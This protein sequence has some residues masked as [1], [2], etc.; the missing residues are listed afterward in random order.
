MVSMLTHYPA[1][2]RRGGPIEEWGHAVDAELFETFTFPLSRG[3]PASALSDPRSL[4]LAPGT[5]AKYFGDADPMGQTLTLKF[6][7]FSRD[8]GDTPSPEVR[9]F[10]VT[11]ILA[12]IPDKSSIR[13]NMVIPK[14]G[15]EDLTPRGTR[16]LWVE[17][18]EGVSPRVVEEQLAK[19]PQALLPPR[20][21][22]GTP[23]SQPIPARH[24]ARLPTHS[25]VH[26]MPLRDVH[27]Q[28]G[29][30][31][32]PSGGDRKRG[33][34]LAGAGL[35]ILLIACINYVNLAVARATTRATEIGIRKAVGADRAQVRRQ[36]M[37]EAI[38]VSFLAVALG[39]G[40]AELLL[41]EFR[42]LVGEDLALDSLAWRTLTA[43][44]VLSLV[45]GGAAGLYPSVLVSRLEP[46]RALSN[47]QRI[48][49]RNPLSRGMIALQ[50]AVSAF[51]VIATLVIHSQI[52][53]MMTKDLGFDSDQVAM[54]YGKALDEGE[55]A[56]REE[57][58]TPGGPVQSLA[59]ADPMPGW[60]TN[61]CTWKRGDATTPVNG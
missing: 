24:L 58:L 54:G 44:T 20:G 42:S 4:V 48:G 16:S 39:L 2:R 41:P 52:D 55:M 14:M 10:T 38:L 9:T 34:V 12:P 29:V 28:E 15:N 46:V 18:A 6:K 31:G 27:W 8:A 45:V 25:K 37:T 60:G 56:L 17:L 59:G 7:R 40:L 5:A 57:H 21:P 23:H 1:V 43:A 11:G 30:F 50:F 19:T 47:R 26:L 36:F 61:L 35:L 53:F 51:L 13:L 32:L 3:D 33:Y 49:G 22:A